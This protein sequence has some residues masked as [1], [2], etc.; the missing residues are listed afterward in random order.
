MSAG[1]ATAD[2]KAGLQ[3]RLHELLNNL[4]NTT[5][6]LKTW[7]ESDDASVHVETT[8]GLIESLQ[9][10]LQSARDVETKVMKGNGTEDDKKLVRELKESP[11][12]LDLLELMDYDVNPDAYARSLL[13]ESL[14]QLAGLKRRKLALELLGNAVEQ[15]MA[16]RKKSKNEGEE[17][18][19]AAVPANESSAS[20]APGGTHRTST[21]SGGTGGGDGGGAKRKRDDNDKS[22]EEPPKKKA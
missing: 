1:A 13:H 5:E 22:L 19:A 17:T 2:P 3:E 4:Y 11:V 16:R 9:Q 6:L 18:A 20:Q 15:G 21:S 14:R 7:P 12:P 8:T 10:V